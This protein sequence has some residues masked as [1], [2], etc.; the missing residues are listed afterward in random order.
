MSEEEKDAQLLAETE[1]LYKIEIVFENE[2]TLETWR[3][4]EEAVFAANINEHIEM[5]ARE[6]TLKRLA[7]AGFLK[8]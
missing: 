7:R 3:E 2:L 8:N 6:K 1:D 4:Y 5:D